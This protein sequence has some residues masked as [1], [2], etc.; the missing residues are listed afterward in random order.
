MVERDLAA[1]TT[2]NLRYTVGQ[3]G[4]GSRSEVYCARVRYGRLHWD[5]VDGKYG[6]EE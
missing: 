6:I 4:Y 5:N 1:A 3:G 2:T